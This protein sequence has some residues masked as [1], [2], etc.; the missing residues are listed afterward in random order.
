MKVIFVKN[1]WLIGM[2]V[3]FFLLLIFLNGIGYFLNL[4]YISVFA[5]VSEE[6]KYEVKSRLLMEAMDYVGS[7][8]PAEAAVTWANGLKMRSAAM[9]YSVLNSELK[10]GYK[11]QLEESAP[12]WVTGISSPWIES[13]KIVKNELEGKDKYKI[14]LIFSTA[15]STGP[16]GDYRAILTLL[17]E[18]DYWRIADISMEQELY[19]YT[20]FK[21]D[22]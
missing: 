11:Q 1:K 8:N 10:K 6:D 3:S 14:E 12:N 7:C 13:Y 20:R 21:P 9:Q 16:A 15:T 2:F 18:K 5:A 17:R 22:S 19:P 4:K